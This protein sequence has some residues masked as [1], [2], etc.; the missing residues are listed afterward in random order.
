MESDEEVTFFRVLSAHTSGD[1]EKYEKSQ[2]NVFLSHH[3][4]RIL[5]ETSQE[6]YR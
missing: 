1:N 5:S 4:S 3:L 2:D 6:R